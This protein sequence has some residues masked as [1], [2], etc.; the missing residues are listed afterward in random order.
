L[1]FRRKIAAFF[2]LGIYTIPIVI[3]LALAVQ[4]VFVRAEIRELMKKQRLETMVLP[5]NQIHWIE[6]E[7]ELLVNGVMFDVHSMKQ[8]P[9][10]YTELIGLTDAKE[11]QLNADVDLLMQH[12]NKL[13]TLLAKIVVIQSI[14]VINTG[15]ISFPSVQLL[16]YR[17][18]FHKILIPV[19]YSEVL[20]P[21]PQTSLF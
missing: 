20:T 1:N 16:Q 19:N 14:G 5:N 13:Q 2:L 17:Y 10:G 21:P 9:G 8:L 15:I 7:T 4:R 3:L 11:N 6:P 18:A 12:K